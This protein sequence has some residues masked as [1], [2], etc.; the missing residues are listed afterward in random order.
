M[1]FDVG[2]FL[3]EI[4]SIASAL[5]ITLILTL[6][7][8]VF[9]LLIGVVVAVAEYYKIAVINQICRVYVS[10]F[11]GTPLLPQLFFFYFGVAYFS[12]IVKNMDPVTAT[13]IVLSLNMGSYMSENIR[14]A[15]LSVDSGQIEAAFSFGMSRFQTMRRII[16]PQAFRVAFPSLFNNF[17]DL[18]K[19]SSMAFVV[20]AVD[21][22]GKAKL[23]AAITFRFFEVYAAV[24]LIYWCIITVLGIV[25]RRIEAWCN[26]AY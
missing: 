6:V 4:P 22:M 11:R 23:D 2:Y 13:A 25:Q 18:L 1:N 16:A 3:E 17:I 10:I 20:G 9:S 14:G 15:L 5:D 8:L 12:D 26:A 21:I 19:S 24:M 7:S